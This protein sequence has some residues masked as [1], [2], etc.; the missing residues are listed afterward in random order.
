M[1]DTPTP[2]PP[3]EEAIAAKRY[4]TMNLLRV[5]AVVAVFAGI[6]IAHGV[7][8]L[9]YALAVLLAVGGMLTFFYGPRTLV[10]HWKAEDERR[11][12]AGN[13]DEP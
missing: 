1:S 2:Q 12:K 7:I 6:A 3:P 5:G 13:R 10:R 11:D 8:D 9:P 4:V